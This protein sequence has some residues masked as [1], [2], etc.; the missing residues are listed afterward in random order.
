MEYRLLSNPDDG[1]TLPRAELRSA[2]VF[3]ARIHLGVSF[4]GETKT[5]LRVS[6]SGRKIGARVTR[7]GDLM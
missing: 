6:D 5:L 1:A 7:A 2:D 3:V 4:L